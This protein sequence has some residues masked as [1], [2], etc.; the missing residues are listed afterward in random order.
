[1]SATK[2]LSVG[3]QSQQNIYFLT[4][5]FIAENSSAV[6]TVDTQTHSLLCFKKNA[7][8]RDKFRLTEEW[9]RKKKSTQKQK[10]TSVLPMEAHRG[11]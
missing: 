9:E 8:R 11:T 5:I 2:Y 3:I 1:M 10:P 7:S 6:S 4:H